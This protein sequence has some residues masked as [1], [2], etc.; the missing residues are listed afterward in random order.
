LERRN[1]IKIA[2]LAGLA[3]ALAPGKTL[4]ATVDGGVTRHTA[5]AAMTDREYHVNLLHRISRPVVENMSKG[6]LKKH[7]PLEKGPGYGLAAEKVTYLEAFGRCISGLAPWLALPDDTTTE[8]K[9]RKQMREQVLQRIVNGVNP[10]SPDYL[11]FRTEGQP[12]VD[13]AYL[14]QTF[15]R[16]PEALWAP[17]DNATKANVVKEGKIIMSHTSFSY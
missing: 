7:M 16:A 1:F 6:T 5:T 3:G 11:N 15:M 12:L 2:P 9:L 4:A 10:A 17:P 14:C 13:A 8:G